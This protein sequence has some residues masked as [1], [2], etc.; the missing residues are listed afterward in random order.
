MKRSE[1]Y[2]LSSESTN[3]TNWIQFVDSDVIRNIRI[4][5]LQ[6]LDNER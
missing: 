1:C 5:F 3:T 2:K 6:A 4:G